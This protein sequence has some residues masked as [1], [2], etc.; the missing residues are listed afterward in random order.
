M[1]R[2]DMIAGCLGFGF[3]ASL[4]G[5]E[6]KS[7]P[8]EKEKFLVCLHVGLDHFS[9][10]SAKRYVQKWQEL[11]DEDKKHDKL[12]F[13]VVPRTGTDVS[14]SIQALSPITEPTDEHI[15]F[16]RS[17]VGMKSPKDSLKQCE[18]LKKMFDRGKRKETL[19]VIVIPVRSGPATLNRIYLDGRDKRHA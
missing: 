14:L 1:R 12:K 3:F 10:E 4:F 13:T 7:A 16:V 17:N 8:V 2:R 19:Q 9:P 5:K 11:L 15:L 6:V 18:E